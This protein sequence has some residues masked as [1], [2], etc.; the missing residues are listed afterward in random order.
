[1]SKAAEIMGETLVQVSCQGLTAM[2]GHHYQRQSA[3]R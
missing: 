3:N 1:M 2:F